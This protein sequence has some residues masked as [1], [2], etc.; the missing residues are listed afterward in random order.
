MKAAKL[1]LYGILLFSMVHCC[2]VLQSRAR[3]T[4]TV[5]FSSRAN[6]SW[7]SVEETDPNGVTGIYFPGGPTGQVI[8]GGIPFDIKANAG[9][10]QAW[11]AY[12]AAGGGSGEQSITIPVDKYGVTD[13]Y[14]LINSFWSFPGP[15]SD[16]WLIFSGSGGVDFTYY[17]VGGSDIRNWCCGGEINGTST[18]NVYTSLTASQ[19]NGAYG[20]LDMQHITLPA[21][22]TNQ[23]LTSITLVDNGNYG[24]QRVILDGVTLIAASSATLTGHVYCT[25]GSNSISG[26][27]VQIGNYSTTSDQ[28]GVY[29]LGN[30]LPGNYAASIS[31]NNFVSATTNVTI[32]SGV[33]VVTNDFYLT[34][35]TLAINPIFDSSITED[36]NSLA[37]TNSIESAI[38]RVENLV[39]NPI[40]VTIKFVETNSGLAVSST[41][42]NNLGYSQYL[43]DLQD[44]QI[45]SANDNSALATLPA[46]PN[47]PV[48]SNA[49]ITLTTPLLRAIGETNLGNVGSNPDSTI[50]LNTANMNL[51]RTGPQILT[52]YDLQSA[53]AH[54]ID[55]ALGVGGAGSSLNEVL[56]GRQSIFDPIG[57]MDLFRYD[58]ATL[59]SY[60][61]NQEDAPYFSIDGGK[62]T[63]VHFNQ[64]TNGDYGD[65][66][67]GSVP[68]NRQGNIPSQVQ[69]AFGSTNG[70]MPNIG[71]NELIALDVVGYNLLTPPPTAQNM[72]YAGGTFTFNW[73][74]VP[75]QSYQVQYT[76]SLSGNVWANL[77][78]TIT[79]SDLTASASDTNASVLQRFYRVGMV[80]QP[81]APAV[82]SGS[83]H[84]TA[85]P[86]AAVTN[87]LA[88]GRFMPNRDR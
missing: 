59:R 84:A 54:E 69:D 71:A 66:G 42:I 52:K 76:T 40:C 50:F 2:F 16:A 43:S 21:T 58:S 62:T 25:C 55:E 78:N 26:A 83:S 67:N 72:T 64:N 39:A 86:A 63:L 47:N 32:P 53:A 19:I 74:T 60:N 11:N 38:L 7:T 36:V 13:V 61:T 6:F 70:A 12:I 46:G 41:S 18:V 57:P 34:N 5:D 79:A 75:G 28:D 35:S 27:L 9:G 23:T 30:L 45:P 56:H 87:T 81:A 8:L 14:T 51:S 85:T 15:A 48:N 80:L 37:I 31:A 33:S 68:A 49:Y 44:K 24:I 65:W 3:M 17:L 88:R 10:Y 1:R 29:A 82:L 22:F 4:N 20:V 73:P 77:G